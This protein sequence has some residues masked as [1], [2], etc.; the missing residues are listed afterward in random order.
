M[1]TPDMHLDP[2]LLSAY[3][4]QEV[5]TEERQLIEA[6]LPTCIA[7][8]RELDSLRFTAAMV[9]ALPARPIPRTFY[10]T[11]AMV[12][13]EPKTQ[14]EG[15][16]GWLRGLAPFGAVLATLL[17]V[18]VLARPLMFG[19]SGAAI[20]SAAPAEAPQIAVMTTEVMEEAGAAESALPEEETG[21]RQSD[22]PDM[23]TAATDAADNT[24]VME[25]PASPT[26]ESAVIEGNTDTNTFSITAPIVGTGGETDP[27]GGDTP[28]H[29]AVTSTAAVP[30]AKADTDE[31]TVSQVTPTAMN[32]I[33]IFTM[34][35]VVVAV[36][37]L[38]IFARRRH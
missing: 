37:T 17:V 19:G 34:I 3:L 13:P 24:A 5:N 7:C 10:V 25:P 30:T 9:Q 33:L 38:V 23:A 20:P 31:S 26:T 21:T 11:E 32:T 2:E 14:S 27:S 29:G 15:W 16:M 1:N 8:V 35:L 18:F 4:D 22:E 12:A 28:T 6:H 36:G